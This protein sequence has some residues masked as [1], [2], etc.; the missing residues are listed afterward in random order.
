MAVQ[1]ALKGF[2]DRQD[3]GGGR[4]PTERSSTPPEDDGERIATYPRGADAELRMVVAE[5]NGRPY[6]GL[7]I[8][9]R[10]GDGA[11]WWPTK[12]GV[13]VRTHELEDFARAVGVAVERLGVAKGGE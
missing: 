12:K 13:T 3:R 11:A 6:L 4:P 5:Y 8:W 7:R 1:D 2:A 9:E 10:D